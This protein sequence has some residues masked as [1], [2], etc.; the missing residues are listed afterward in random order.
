V[1]RRPL[2][3]YQLEVARAIVDSVLHKRGLEFAVM[4]PRQSGKNETQAQVEAYLLNLFQRVRGAQ[5]VKASPTWK[6]Q[7]INAMDRLKM[8]LANDWNRGRWES[9]HGYEVVMGEAKISFFS[10]SPG[11]NVVGATASV[12][13]EC[14]E[15]QDV[16]EAE[17]GKKFEPMAANTNATVT[18]WGT[19]WTSRT[20]LAKTVARLRA[21]EAADGIR[22]VF[23]VT[24]DEVAK[25]N[26]SYA[27]FAKRQIAKWGRQHP[28]VRTQLYNE[29]IDAQGGMFPAARRALMQGEHGRMNAPLPAKSYALCIDVAGEDESGGDVLELLANPRRDATALTVVEVDT[30]TVGDELIRAPSYRVVNRRRWVG[31]KHSSLYAEIRAIA[32]HWGA[33]YV[34]VDATGVGAGLASFL[35]KAL[36]GRVIQFEFNS[37]TKSEL[38]WAFLAA[39]DTG[40][41]K[42]YRAQMGDAESANFWREVEHCLYEVAPGPG[43]R[44]KWGVPDGTRDEGGELVHDDL[45]VSAALCAALDAVEWDRLPAGARVADRDWTPGL[46]VELAYYQSEGGGLAFLLLQRGGEGVFVFDEM[47]AVGVSASEAVAALVARCAVYALPAL[48]VGDPKSA[49]LRRAL[50]LAGMVGRGE[51]IEAGAAAEALAVTRRVLAEKVVAIHPRCVNLIQALDSGGPAREALTGY[52]WNRLRR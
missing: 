42:D 35:D 31:V 17:W 22:R 48:A 38:G 11:A 29:E 32:Q 1:V 19:A 37:A 50:R 39:C 51:T 26:P 45:I 13:L 47:M 36:P 18:Y 21:L 52:C 14:D 41:F 7:S 33:R 8:V 27:E 28:F 24:P 9:R 12:W 30:S 5:I 23:V 3:G 4:F 43:R 2:R 46:A 20:M 44:A 34:V 16:L 25:E 6:P 49:E 40:R 10:A 15:A